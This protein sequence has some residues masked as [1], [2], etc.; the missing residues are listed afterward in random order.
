MGLRSRIIVVVAVSSAIINFF[1]CF[2]FTEQIGRMELD[3]LNERIDGAVQIMKIINA[4]PLFNVDRDTLKHN[5]ATFFGD[6]NMKR[7]AIET[8]DIGTNFYIE[9]KIEPGGTDIKRRFDIVHEGQ[10]LGRMSVVYATGLIEKKMAEFR[11]QMLVFSFIV[12]AVFVLILTGLINRLL[13]PVTRLSQAASQIAAGNL[14]KEIEQTGQGEIGELARNFAAMQNA[15]KEKITA[16]A[17]TNAELEQEI[18]NK[19]QTEEKILRQSVVISS[20]KNI[21]QKSMLAQSS[22]DVARLFIPIA[23]EVI[24]SRTCFIGH[25]RGENPEE[26]DI[27]AASENLYADQGLNKNKSIRVKADGALS[28]VIR[29]NSPVIANELGSYPLFTGPASGHFHPDNFMGIPIWLGSQIEGIIAFAG[30]SSG[31]DDEDLEDG[32]ILALSLGEA[33]NLKQKENE[34]ARLEK[35]MIHSEKMASLGGM[36]AGLAHEINNPLAG[37]L[38]NAQVIESR[39]KTK[40]P[41]NLK[42][43]QEAR[44]DLDSLHEYMEKRKI[45]AM[46]GSIMAAGK[47]AAAIVSNMLSFSR[48]SSGDLAFENISDLLDKTV[49]LAQSDYN[50]KTKFDFRKIDIVKAYE[51]DTPACRC[52]ASEIQQVFF[53]VLS[54]GAQAMMSGPN[55]GDPRFILKVFADQRQEG[56]MVCIDIQDNGPGMDDQTRKRIFDP[57]FT[58]KDVGDGTG[59]GLSISY[60]IVTENHGGQ[61]EVDS[62]PGEGCCF[63]IRLPVE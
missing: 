25:R 21:F 5:M 11:G 9:R 1:L 8:S 20:V 62:E 28:Q 52:R 42:A 18:L 50:L 48:K 43:A 53:N 16:L 51:P 31:Y 4:R 59:L 47:R 2:Y 63:R 17:R 22:V 45:Y 15:V 14:D 40:L 61:I 12:T 49:E 35:M 46:L 3:A 37:I 6:K 23:M 29:E 19:E 13:R 56:D 41:A 26:L 30:K 34:K 58:T 39:L 60:F 7:I 57:F 55:T 10:W 24:P 33:L 27:L 32:L 44:L 36:A 38:Q 54:N